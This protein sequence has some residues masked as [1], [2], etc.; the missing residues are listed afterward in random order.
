M[1]AGEKRVVPVVLVASDGHGGSQLSSD[2]LFDGRVVACWAPQESDRV[3]APRRN[4]TVMSQ[5]VMADRPATMPTW[6][7]GRRTTSAWGTIWV[8]ASTP[9][10][11][12]MV[13]LAAD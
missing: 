3:I 8:I 6:P 1:P 2:L 7:P 9:S 13:S 4:F 12:A 5:R 10:G 11:G